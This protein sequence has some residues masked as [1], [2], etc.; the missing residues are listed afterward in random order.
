MKGR[1]ND[2]E[3]RKMNRA[4]CLL[5]EDRKLKTPHN[6]VYQMLGRKEYN[7]G[8]GAGDKGMVLVVV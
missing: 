4:K 3:E 2:E 6:W 8:V 5:Q 1:G 7:R